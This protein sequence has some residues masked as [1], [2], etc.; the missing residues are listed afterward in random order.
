MAD[1][2]I[3]ASTRSRQAPGPKDC[4]SGPAGATARRIWVIDQADA[5]CRRE[6]HSKM[7]R[8][9][10]SL[11]AAAGPPARSRARAEAGLSIIIPLYNEAGGLVALHDRIV[12]VANR[13]NHSHRLVA[14]VIYV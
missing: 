10:T 7:A 2:A 5:E 1:A 8:D 4:P 12:D 6:R 11:G 9:A 13:L 3:A 14:E